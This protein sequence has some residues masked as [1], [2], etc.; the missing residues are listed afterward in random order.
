MLV[1]YF[2]IQIGHQVGDMRKEGN[3]PLRASSIAAAVAAL[4]SNEESADC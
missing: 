1:V 2:S 4:G 3:L